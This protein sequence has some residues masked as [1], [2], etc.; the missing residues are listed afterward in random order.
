M[1]KKILSFVLLSV[2]ISSYSQSQSSDRTIFDDERGKSISNENE[3]KIFFTKLK[4][5]RELEKSSLSNSNTLQAA[6][7]MCT[8]NGFEQ[9]E[10]VSGAQVLKNFQYTIGDPPGPTQCNSLTNTANTGIGIYN[11]SNMSVMATTVPANLIDPYIGNI[12]AFDQYAL[13]INYDNSSTYGS[14][15]QGKRFKTNNEN[16][17]KFNFKAVLMT[18]YDTGHTDNQP[19]VKAR[20]INSSGTVVDEFCLIGDETN[21]IFTVIPDSSSP[22]LYTANWQSGLLDIS[23]IPNNEEFTVEFMASR[24]GFGAHFGYMYVDDICILHSSENLQGSIELDPLNKV[25]SNL[26]INVCGSYTIPNSGGITATLNSIT[27]NLYNSAGVSVYSTTTTSSLDTVNQKFCFVLNANDFPNSLNANYNVGVTANYNVS[28]STPCAGTSFEPASDPDANAGWDISFQNCSSCS[29][30]VTT[31]KLSLCD[32]NHDGMEIFNLQNA[33]NSIVSSTAGITFSYFTTFNDANSNINAISTS[34]AYSSTSKTIYVRVSQSASCYRVIAILLEV[35]NPFVNISGILNVCSGSTVLTASA[36]SSYLWNNGSTTQS[37]TV[38]TIG[39]YSVTVT[40]SS[41]CS[42]VATV[43]IEPTQVATT[44][45]VIVSQPSCFVTTGTIEVTSPGAQFSFDNGSTWTTNPIKTGLYPGTYQVKLKTINNCISY[46]LSVTIVAALT[47]YPN[48]TATNPAYCGDFGSITITTSAAFYSFDNGVT[49]VTNPTATNL[50]N[51]TYKIRTKDSQGCISNFNSVLINSVT[52]E[53]PI[54]TVIN[55]AC[56]TNG[57][58]TIAT[59]ADF[60]TFDGGTTWTTNNILTN[61]ITGS[62][63]IAVKNNLGCTSEFSNAYVDDLQN[64]YPDALTTQ[65]ICGAGGS[66][67]ITTVANFYSFD[68]GVTWSTSNVATNLPPATYIIKVKNASGCVSLPSYTY[69]NVPYIDAPIIQITQP[70]CGVNGSITINTLSD[71][72]SFDGGTTWVTNNTMSLPSGSYEII[73]KNNLGCVSNGV[74]AP[75]YQPTLPN[76][77]YTLIQPTCSNTGSVTFITV[78]AFYSIDGGTTWST[79]PTFTNLSGGYINLKIKNSTGCESQNIYENLNTNYLAQ[80]TFTATNPSCGN[81]GSITFT[82]VASF[83]S[84]N[85]GS[86]WSTSPS[87]TN[88]SSGYYTLL[89]KNNVGCISDYINIYL[90]STYLSAPTAALVYPC[91]GSNGSITFTTTAAFYSINDGTT[92]SSNPVFSN[93]SAGY[94]YLKIKNS[95]G[96]FSESVTV[97]F[98]FY[99]AMPNATIVQPICGTNGSIT[100]NTVAAFYS[101]N[102]GTTWV[103]NPVFP[104]LPPAYY[105]VMIKNASG[106]TSFINYVTLSQPFIPAPL[107]TVVQPTCGVGGMIT[108][109]TPAAQYSK[110]GGSTWQTSNVFSNLTSGYYNIAI[111]NSLGCTSY[112]SST[113]IEPY[114]LPNPNITIVQPTCGSNG[115]ITIA[116]AASQYSFDG[117]TTWTINP[118]LSNL[119]NG[120]YNVCIKNTLGCTSNPYNVNVYIHTYYLPNPLVTITQPTCGNTGNISVL[121]A[122]DFYSFDNGVTWTTNSVLT[123][124]TPGTYLVKVKNNLGCV[125]QS[126]YVYIYQN[127]LPSPSVTITQPTCSSPFGTI[128]VNSPASQYSFDNGVTWVTNSTLTNLAPSSYYIKTKNSLGCESNSYY[129]YVY[130][131]PFIPTA[132]LITPFMPSSCGATDG[133]IT[134]VTPA[135]EYSFNN[136]VTWTTNPT[137]INLAAGTYYIKTRN[138]SSTCESAAAIITLNSGTAIA[139]P[140]F[141][142]VNPGCSNLNGSITITTSASYYSFDDGVTFIS[143]NTKSNLPAGIYKLKIKSAEGCISTSATATIS[144]ALNLPPPSSTVTQ[145]DCSNA[146]GS[147]VIT[148]A[149]NEFSFDNGAT[150]VTTNTL[151]GLTAGTYLIK[152]KDSTG[153]ESTSS[154]ITINSQPTT[155]NA[156]AITVNHPLTCLIATG[157]ITVTSGGALFSFDN[158][159]TWNSNSTSAPLNSGTYQV[160]VKETASGCPSFASTAIINAPPNAPNPPTFTTVQPTTCANPFGTIQI[161]SIESQYSFDNGVTYSTNSTS[162][163]LPAGTYQIRVKNTDGCES[164]AVSVAIIAP[165]DYPNNPNYTTIQPDCNNPNGAITITD[166]ATEYSFDDGATWISNATQSNLTPG[167]YL[168]KVKSSIGCSSN[169]TTVVLIPF[170][171][172]TPLPTATSPQTFCIQQNA[173]INDVPISGSN[174]KWYDSLTAGNLLPNATILVDGTTY[175]ASQTINGCESMRIPIIISIQNTAAPSGDANQTFC[176]TANPTVGTIVLSGTALN[177]YANNSSTTILPNSTALVDG[178]TYFATQTVNGCESVTRF[179][180][181]VSLITSLNANDYSQS[182]CDDLNDGSENINLSNYNSNFVASTPGMTF[183]YYS[184]L[185]GAENQLASQQLNSNYSLSVGSTIVYVRLDSTNGCHQIV[186]LNL[187]LF[188][189]PIISIDDVMPICQSTSITVNAGSGFNSYSW[190]TGATTQSIS[191]S[192]P[193]TY[194]VTVTKNYGTLICSSTKSFNV[195]AS[196]VA[197]I[198]SIDTQDWT[199]TENVI[200]VSTTINDNFQY[201]LDGVNYQVSNT[202]SGLT[203]GFYTVYVKDECGIV[204]EDVVLLN[205]PKFFTPNDDGTNDYWRIKFSQ[206]E[207]N[208]TVT[209]FDRYGKIMKVLNPNSVG[210]DGTYN[211]T[212]V[213]S[214]DYWFVVKREDGREHRAHFTLKR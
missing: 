161:T 202:F 67:V 26:P 160:L 40:D 91:N 99:L 169:A 128:T 130:S 86:T 39:T 105:S 62:Y 79:N 205:Y 104:N 83:Y 158:G 135:S 153:C 124:P 143:S 53:T 28:G 166:V 64:T 95:A 22:I 92:W 181:T 50:P 27:L 133:S 168:I 63:S 10:T 1:L 84:I 154:S 120:Y 175:Y 113:Q 75:L 122:A 44:P 74:Y 162:G 7:E 4:N 47:S 131:A 196:Q 183:T 2:F 5:K 132:P 170:T 100:I 66:I 77:Q 167:T 136:G 119:T 58:I 116:T 56:G 176:A 103:T 118:V 200:I 199:D 32:S 155:P 214:D 87:F 14:I 126:Q 106:C 146:T 178:T 29:L 46:S 42:N 208:L 25:C 125:S 81:I 165:T 18:V 89:V 182:F 203:S 41:G 185:N 23:S 111:K 204:N 93:L 209:I 156:P 206:Y 76:P 186:K 194:S 90:N 98:D 188:Q 13:K 107:F 112:S 15:V 96:C 177:W 134:V 102:G 54:F 171:N 16:Y 114:Y 78:A 51:G 201:S 55:P 68:N 69:L 211:G 174:I 12:N 192:I 60:Y 20:I 33:N 210:W 37:I 31:T 17:L 144:T 197:T 94:Y 191:I 115:S 8:N 101:I 141:T 34:T 121:S 19:F 187:S 38:T 190:S 71:F 142:V 140:T 189:K 11:P 198:A 73:I 117:G 85:G 164:T 109:T 179:S 180:V 48:F 207:P 159:V 80:P 129:A 127:Y 97:Y 108:V 138:N 150:W 213:I 149:A 137:K 157:T 88:L 61:L 45:N 3:K 145:P 151:S 70:Q 65:P 173:T 6:V 152:I 21:C 82:T 212:K 193:G 59:I 110:D 172:F 72:Y 195:V 49:W 148:A 24:C 147:I 52:L 163:N 9:H 35:K 43:T 123:N 139:S 30:D 184:S 36:G 57:S